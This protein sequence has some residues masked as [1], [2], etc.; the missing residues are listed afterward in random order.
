MATQTSTLSGCCRCA[1]P[2]HPC[3]PHVRRP[4]GE[5]SHAGILLDVECFIHS[6][7]PCAEADRPDP[8]Y[9]TALIAA[10]HTTA[11]RVRIVAAV[12]QK[13]PEY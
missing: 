6:C 2:V 8:L 9:A 11:K 10:S 4:S 5:S 13:R 1:Y 7:G 12:R 3:G